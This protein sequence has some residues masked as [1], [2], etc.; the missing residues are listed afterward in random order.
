MK[1]ARQSASSV[2]TPPSAGP[3]TAPADPASAQIARPLRSP[4]ARATSAGS[5]AASSI[6]PP[7]PCTPRSVTSAGRSGA[8]PQPS[9]AAA[10][11]ARPATSTGSGRTRRITGI[12]TNA[13]AATTRLYEVITKEAP[14]MD[15]SSSP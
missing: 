8:R 10:K 6:A 9:D 13:A 5:D 4:S 2:M 15:A 7:S 12:S 1:I 11:I 3:T 14:G